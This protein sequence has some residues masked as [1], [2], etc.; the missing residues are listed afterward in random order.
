MHRDLAEDRVDRRAQRLGAVQDNQDALLA[1][2]A[3][4]HEVAQQLAADRRV[5]RRA[6]PQAQRDLDAFGRHAQRHDAAAALQ[7]QAVEHQGG[8]ANVG[9]RPAHQRA[10]LLAGP[11]DELAADRALGGRALALSDVLADWL[12]R[13]REAARADAGEHLLEHDRG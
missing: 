3:A 10:Q 13:A 8:E 11:A 2:Q 4:V 5:L 12:S 9:Q 7:L 6:V 1:V